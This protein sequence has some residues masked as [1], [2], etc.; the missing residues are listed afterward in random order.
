[1]TSPEKARIDQYRT[2]FIRIERRLR[3]KTAMPNQGLRDVIRAYAKKHAGWKHAGSLE[4]L[5]QLRNV[6]AHN[7]GVV[8]YMSVPT[9]EALAELEVVEKALIAPPL[10]GKQF[11]RAVKVVAPKQTLSSVLR[12]IHDNDYSQFPVVEGRAISGLLT[13]NGIAHWLARHA[14]AGTLRHDLTTA[15][16]EHVLAVQRERNVHAV[17]S[18]GTPVTEVEHMFANRPTLEAVIVTPTGNPSLPVIGIATQW[19]I[20]CLKR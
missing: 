6:I 18:P 3:A 1:M 8:E 12:L 10:A 2:L 17:V 4:G 9:A 19:D 7:D 15:Q 20:L 11:K 14:K 16:V 5:Y 13:E